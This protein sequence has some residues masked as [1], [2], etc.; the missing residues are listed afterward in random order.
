MHCYLIP[1]AWSLRSVTDECELFSFHYKDFLKR[2]PSKAS[3]Y[4]IL[5][6]VSLKESSGYQL[7]FSLQIRK[8]L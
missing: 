7:S 6:K 5:V 4:Y 8:V 3:Y 1:S 2:C